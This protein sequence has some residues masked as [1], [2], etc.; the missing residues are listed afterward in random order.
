M[1]K[2]APNFESDNKIQLCSFFFFFFF[3]INYSQEESYREGRRAA[4]KDRG[5]SKRE[6]HML[7]CIGIGVTHDT[8][9]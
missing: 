6:G 3:I 9:L 2:D 4:N 5:E 1:R 8:R 7:P